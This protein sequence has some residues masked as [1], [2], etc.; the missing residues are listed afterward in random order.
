VLHCI[1]LAL[2]LCCLYD[3]SL[4]C[5]PFH[6]NSTEHSIITQSIITLLTI[7]VSECRASLIIFDYIILTD[8]IFRVIL[9][10]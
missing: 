8:Y 5:L 4:R 1:A 6:I 9:G 2:Q 3:A 7:I 10:K